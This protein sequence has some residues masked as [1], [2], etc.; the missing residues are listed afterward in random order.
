MA[1]NGRFSLNEVPLLPHGILVVPVGQLRFC[2]S[3]PFEPPDTEMTNRAGAV[4]G[5][6]R[7]GR[8]RHRLVNS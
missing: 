3:F 6:D 8:S 4:V 1:T 5:L 7:R 2:D